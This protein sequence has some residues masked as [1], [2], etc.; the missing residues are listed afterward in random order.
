MPI[1]V[2][3]EGAG[4]DASPAPNTYNL[5]G[6]HM[7]KNT[8]V[9]AEAAFK[10][11]FVAITLVENT[12]QRI[13]LVYYGL[14]RS[15][16]EPPIPKSTPAPGHYTVRDDLLHQS[17]CTH[18]SVFNSHSKRETLG[19]PAKVSESSVQPRLVRLLPKTL[20]SLLI[21]LLSLSL[22]L[23]L[24]HDSGSRPCGLQSLLQYKQQ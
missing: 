6:V 22:S 18:Q 20:P 12:E 23:S 2:K 9:T 24:S 17:T 21:A 19:N 8:L 13:L 7:G 11:R 5:S 14:S 10:S 3:E 16:R 1:A 4:V 15:K